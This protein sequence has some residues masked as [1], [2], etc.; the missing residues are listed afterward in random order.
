[1][2]KATIFTIFFSILVVTLVAQLL[3]NDHLRSGWT[4]VVPPGETSDDTSRDVAEVVRDEVPGS[5]SSA[6]VAPIAPPPIT[7]TPSASPANTSEVSS[8]LSQRG[9][10][11]E[12]ITTEQL[13]GFGFE[14]MRLEQTSAEGLLFQLIDVSDV[15]NLSKVRYNLTDGKSIYGVISEFLLADDGKAGGFYESLKQKGSAFAPEVK[16][17]ETN[18]FGSRSFYLNDTKRIGTA[19]LAVLVKNRVFTFSYPKASHEFFKK[20]INL[21]AKQ[22]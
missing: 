4:S 18:V 10:A 16:L 5:P 6:P 22:P 19:F 1:M 9:Y 12:K 3:V 21:L 13:T 17:N 14:A 11:I 20:L 8:F 15:V 2:Q 7:P